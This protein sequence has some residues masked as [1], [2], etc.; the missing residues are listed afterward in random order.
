MFFTSDRVRMHDLVDELAHG[1]LEALV[2]LIVVWVGEAGHEPGR[3]CIGYL[4]NGVP[5]ER[6]DLRLLALDGTDLQARVLRAVEYLLSVQAEER[7]GGVFTRYR[8]SRPSL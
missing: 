1:L 5:C 7:V 3:L 2:A 4:R 6:L 8:A